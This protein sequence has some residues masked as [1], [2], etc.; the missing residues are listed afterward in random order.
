[1]PRAREIL[2]MSAPEV[3][4]VRRARRG[5]SIAET[6]ASTTALVPGEFK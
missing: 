4:I 6:V 5:T 2:D 3:L 1:M